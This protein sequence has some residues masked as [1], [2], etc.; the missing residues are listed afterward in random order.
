MAKRKPEISG[1]DVA[2]EIENGSDGGS[3]DSSKVVWLVLADGSSIPA[4]I[5]NVHDDRFVDLEADWMGQQLVITR[6]PRD[7]SGKQP[8][9]WRPHDHPVK[10]K[11]D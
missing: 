10:A 3:P 9:S 4:S 1:N 11:A 2:D 5:T 8:D 6:S 7:D